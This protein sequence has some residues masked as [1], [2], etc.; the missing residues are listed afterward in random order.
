ME[1]E[2]IGRKSNFYEEKKFRYQ[3]LLLLIKVPLF[4]FTKEKNKTKN[5]FQ[6]HQF[7]SLNVQK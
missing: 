6:G 1:N 3:R 2:S 7:E 5:K 4:L